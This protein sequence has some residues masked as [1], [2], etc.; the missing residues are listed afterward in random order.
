MKY[1]GYI[2]LEVTV[3]MFSTLE[4]VTGAIKNLI[5]PLQLT[6]FRFFIGG[7]VMLP[8][9]IKK[10]EKVQGKDLLFFL[11]LGILNIFTSIGSLQYAIT[12][13]KLQQRLY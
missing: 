9:V 13:G 5:N 6:F 12:M 10:R 8:L 1:R 11:A 3:L 7:V 4:V 2:L